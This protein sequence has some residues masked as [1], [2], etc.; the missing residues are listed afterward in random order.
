MAL[1]NRQ[2]QRLNNKCIGTEHILL[3]LAEEGSGVGAN[4]LKNLGVD[5][6]KMSLEVEKR[7]KI[8]TD[9]AV[10][11]KL[12]QTPG[13]KRAIQYAMEEARD[14]N[15]DYVGTEHFVLGLL[16]EHDGVAAKVLM[17]FGLDLKTIRGEILNI[18]KTD[19]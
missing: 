10:W 13:A 15:H 2:A 9:A 4:V 11:G 7:I 5:L 14:I 18:L 3:A 6:R 16:R 17:D 1:A 12:P 19:K 8:G